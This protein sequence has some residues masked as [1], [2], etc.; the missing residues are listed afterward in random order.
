MTRARRTRPRRRTARLPATLAAC[1]AV[2]SAVGC[3]RDGGRGFAGFAP[4][5][6]LEADAADDGGPASADVG[7]VRQA[8]ARVPD[9]PEPDGSDDNPFRTLPADPPAAAAASDAGVHDAATLT[10]IEEE[11]ADAAPDERASLAAEWADLD[12]AMVQQVIRI[13]RMV[14][15]LDDERAAEPADAGPIAATPPPVAPAAPGYGA[16]T[17]ASAAPPPAAAPPVSTAY[18]TTPAAAAAAPPPAPPAYAEAPPTPGTAA[19]GTAGPGAFPRAPTGPPPAG[20]TDGSAWG[21]RLP[22]LIAAAERRAADARAALTASGGSPGNADARDRLTRAEV[23]LR[24]LYLLGDDD[25][26]ALEVIPGLDPAEQEFWQQTL[27]ALSNAFDTGGLPDPADRATQV[28]ASLRTAAARLSSKARLSL[29]NVGFCHEIQS[30]GSVD[31]FDRDEFTPGQPV[32]VYAEVDNFRSEQTLEGRFR[33]VL[34][35][36]IDI[37]RAGSGELVESIDLNPDELVD[38][39]D[40]HRRDYFLSFDLQIPQGIGFGPHVLTLRVEDR[41]SGQKAD[42]EIRFTVR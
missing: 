33:T 38:L 36:S 7:A 40:S 31:A 5:V 4:P 27:W 34:R 20:E 25:A 18:A 28:V 41:N 13:R 37:R 9:Q 1:A 23:E 6:R 12:S 24:L 35:S 11:L 42:A 2:L 8:A 21:R 15:Q 26:R 10:L 32:L 16:V 30:F 17:R 14:R 39:C 3:A 22:E 29:R 19:P